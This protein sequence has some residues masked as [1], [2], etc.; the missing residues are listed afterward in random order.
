MTT[1]T[2]TR[3]E[4][5]IGR[6]GPSNE[7][8]RF[9]CKW[10]EAMDSPGCGPDQRIESNYEQERTFMTGGSYFLVNRCGGCG[11]KISGSAMQSGLVTK[12]QS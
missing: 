9:D 5:V 2:K 11:Q 3:R 12:E 8:L 1:K 10:N 6:P 7:G 4:P